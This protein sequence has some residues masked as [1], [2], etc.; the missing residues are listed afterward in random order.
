M[1]NIFITELCENGVSFQ[2][3]E[4]GNN[5]GQDFEAPNLPQKED[6]F[7][8]LRSIK[9]FPMDATSNV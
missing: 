4:K 9:I 5:H 2:K 8:F 6:R 3:L 1:F 7:S